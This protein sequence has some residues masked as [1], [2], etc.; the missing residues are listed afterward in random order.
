MKTKMKFPSPN[1]IFDSIG[2]SYYLSKGV[3]Y[4]FYTIKKD[5]F[6]NLVSITTPLD[7]VI[8]LTNLT[9]ICWVF[10]DQLH[11]PLISTSGSIIL[12]M[13]IVIIQKL[14]IVHPFI[15]IILNFFNRHESFKI[16]HNLNWIDLQVHTFI[17]A[18]KFITMN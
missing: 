12:D 9:F 13:S 15:L 10:F 1:N 11:Q 18:M 4:L 2:F 5:N 17:I 14:V 8:F 16:I 3:G 6:G 7:L